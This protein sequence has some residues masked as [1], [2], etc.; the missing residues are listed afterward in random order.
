MTKLTAGPWNLATGASVFAQVVAINIMG[1]SLT[2]LTGNGAV[3]QISTVP[4]A[5]V[6]LR[7]DSI[8]TTTT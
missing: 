8:T 6:N 3:L 1:P 4:S 7:K 5:P 2:S